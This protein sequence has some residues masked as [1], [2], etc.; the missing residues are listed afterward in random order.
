MINDPTNVP[1]IAPVA[2]LIADFNSLYDISSPIK[3]PRKSPINAPRGGNIIKPRTEPIRPERKAFLPAP[4]YFAPKKPDKK[5]TKKDRK[6]NPESI[7]KLVMVIVLNP[8]K[9][10][11]IK[12]RNTTH[13]NAGKTGK[14][15]RPSDGNINKIVTDSKTKCSI[16]TLYTDKEKARNICCGLKC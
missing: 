10:P 6:N 14:K 5:S 3:T 2:D 16:C 15:I 13:E 11:Y 7:R 1:N 8:S 9:T 4:Q 12:D